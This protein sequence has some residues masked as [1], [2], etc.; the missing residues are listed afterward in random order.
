[1]SKNSH[2]FVKGFVEDEDESIIHLPDSNGNYD[3]LCG[4]D[5][6]DSSIGHM[7]VVPTPKNAKVN[8][9]TCKQIFMHC[10]EFKLT[11]FK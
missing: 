7:G 6:N 11:D 10:R 8:C 9:L 2:R 4:I 1:M 5:F 3:T